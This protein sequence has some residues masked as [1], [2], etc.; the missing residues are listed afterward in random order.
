[1]VPAVAEQPDAP[2]S[3]PPAEHSPKSPEAQP[4]AEPVPLQAASPGVPEAR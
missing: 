3:E 4:Q 1:V 2:Q